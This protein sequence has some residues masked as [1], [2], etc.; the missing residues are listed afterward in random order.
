MIGTPGFKKAKAEKELA[1]ICRSMLFLYRN[2]IKQLSG[3][4]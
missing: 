4:G 3:R 2:K 1:P